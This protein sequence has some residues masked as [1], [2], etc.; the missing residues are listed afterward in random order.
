MS[1]SSVSVRVRLSLKTRDAATYNCTVGFFKHL[2]IAYT[3]NVQV[4]TPVAELNTSIG[5]LG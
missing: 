1:G 5:I 3:D 4:L 2:G